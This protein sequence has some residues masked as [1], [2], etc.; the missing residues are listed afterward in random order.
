[1]SD[2]LRPRLRGKMGSRTR[3]PRLSSHHPTMTDTDAQTASVYR[4]LLMTKT[5]TERFE[6]GLRM[7]EA[8]REAVVASL[9][10]QTP[11][12]RKVAILQRYY[13]RDFSADELSRIEQA[14]RSAAG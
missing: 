4:E 1:M 2:W 13:S 6:M 11:L 12:E 14:L 8:A 10:P 9:P 5:P 7:C 3:R